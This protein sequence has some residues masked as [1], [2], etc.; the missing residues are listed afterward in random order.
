[1]E[2][3]LIDFRVGRV[4]PACPGK[5]PHG[6][7][8]GFISRAPRARLGGYF[9]DL[10]DA[11]KVGKPQILLLAPCLAERWLVYLTFAISGTT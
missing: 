1:M 5:G 9:L 4:A 3:S 6:R 2:K 11:W 7:P 8:L 10:R